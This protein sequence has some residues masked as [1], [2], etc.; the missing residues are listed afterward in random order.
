MTKSV[1]YDT[2]KVHRQFIM[3]WWI[4]TS[5]REGVWGNQSHTVCRA[6]A[7]ES[8]PPFKEDHSRTN[9]VFVMFASAFVIELRLCRFYAFQVQVFRCGIN[10]SQNKSNLTD[11]SSS[12]K[13][14]IILS[15][16]L[17]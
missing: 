2:L 11:F 3:G 7:H 16:A 15:L 13:K 14:L 10:V 9:Q 4:V 6:Y 12:C 1:G 17:E 8:Y 5:T